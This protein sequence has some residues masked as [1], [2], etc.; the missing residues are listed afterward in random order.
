MSRRFV[1]VAVRCLVVAAGL[2]G[3]AGPASASPAAPQTDV[4]GGDPFRTAAG[5]RCAVSFTVEGGF[6]TARQ[7]ASQV[8]EPVY[9]PGGQRMGEVAAIG[10]ATSDYAFVRLDAGWAPVGKIRAGGSVVPVA[11]AV[12]AP[13]GAGVCRYGN[14]TGWRCGTVLAKN[15]TVSYAGGV[16]HGLT[17]TSVCSEP[18]DSG[19]PF[20]AGSQAQGITSGGSGNCTAGGTTY[21]QPVAAPL[22]ALGLTLLTSP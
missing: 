21:F 7:C 10:P 12:S 18:G 6:L 2:L 9:T 13:V 11:G 8:G 5:G 15:V 3:A 17:R 14:T 16:L 20:M 1:H 4:Y 22:A 19:G